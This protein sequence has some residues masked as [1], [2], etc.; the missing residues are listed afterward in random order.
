MNHRLNKDGT[1]RKRKDYLNSE[2]IYY[3]QRHLEQGIPKERIATSCY[4]DIA[5]VEVV[6]QRRLKKLKLSK[7][8]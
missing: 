6:E 4:C 1:Q 7:A 3:I 5:D 8:T 2:E